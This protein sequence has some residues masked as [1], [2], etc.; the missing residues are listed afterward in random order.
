[1]RRPLRLALTAALASLAPLSVYAQGTAFFAQPFKYTDSNGTGT[2]TVTALS[3]DTTRSR[4][5]PVSVILDLNNVH[6]A[7]SGVY[8]YLEDDDANLP[9]FVLLSFTL[10]DPQGNARVYQGTLAAVNGYGGSGTSWPVDSPQ[11]TSRWQVQ[12]LTPLFGNSRLVVDPVRLE[13]GRILVGG[14]KTLTLVLRNA[15]TGLL[16]GTVGTLPEP[17]TIVQGAGPFSRLAGEEHT[18]VVAFAPTRVS[19]PGEFQATLAITSN[20]PNGPTVSV[21]ITGEGTGI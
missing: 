18:V 17:F 3:T 9:P 5:Q 11:T 4:F 14:R 12:S 15:G 21:T 16:T 20:D 19:R 2:L 10:V 13:F 6:S 8:H 1:M 7:G